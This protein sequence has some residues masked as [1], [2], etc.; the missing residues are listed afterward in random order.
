MVTRGFAKAVAAVS[1]FGVVNCESA[2]GN[3]LTESPIVQINYNPNEVNTLLSFQNV[4]V[5][6]RDLFLRQ[7]LEPVSMLRWEELVSE[8][9]W[10]F[11]VEF[12]EP[13][14][15]SGEKA[16]LYLRHTTE[17][18]EIGLFRGGS[19]EFHGIMAGIEF[20]GKSVELI[21]THNNGEDYTGLH[22]HVIK[23][24]SINPRRL[25]GILKLVMKVISTKNNIKIELYA[26]KNLIYDGF[27]LYNIDKAREL[28]GYFG[29]LAEYNDVS[30][31]K[32]F[33]IR[34]AQLFSRVESAEYDKYMRKTPFQ[35]IGV[36]KK[37]HILH[38]NSDIRELIERTEHLMA[39][40]RR[41]F[42]EMSENLVVKGH[43]LLDKELTGLQER[44]TRLVEMGSRQNR[45]SSDLK[46][47]NNLE[48]EFRKLKRGVSDLKYLVERVEADYE[49]NIPVGKYLLLMAGS[50][51]LG[52]LIYREFQK[53]V[54]IKNKP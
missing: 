42:G 35:S 31:S 37:E 43:D 50:A 24:D 25:R 7:G 13:N 17:K 4:N 40:V 9:D 21:Y 2:T 41:I 23:T 8:E 1:F 48:I 5:M 6:G 36:R 16:G 34:N 10:S 52:M 39:Y 3:E 29:L 38:P 47:M 15:E 19:A 14:L 18:P 44:I 22:N 27:H 11:T 26:D 20:N 12:D 53:S 28:K 54:I 51:V 32:A 30:S 33:L 46:A 49:E 45:T